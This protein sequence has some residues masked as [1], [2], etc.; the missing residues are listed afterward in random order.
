VKARQKF[1]HARNFLRFVGM[2]HFEGMQ[3]KI[4]SELLIAQF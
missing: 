2:A 4:P 3:K 1:Y